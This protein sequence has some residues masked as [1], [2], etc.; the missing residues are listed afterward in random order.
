MYIYLCNARST[1]YLLV[2]YT[3]IQ[4]TDRGG[5]VRKRARLWVRVR[6]RPSSVDRRAFISSSQE[7]LGQS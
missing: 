4:L 7:L 3:V 2:I 1:S 5:G 6:R